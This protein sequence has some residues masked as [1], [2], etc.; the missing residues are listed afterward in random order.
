MHSS[1]EHLK[2]LIGLA[3]ELNVP[4]L[5]IHAFTDGRDTSPTSGAAS[6]AGDRGDLPRAGHRPDR[7]GDRPL[8]RD[9]PRPALGPDRAGRRPALR[10]DRAAP[11]RHRRA[12]GEGRLRARRDRRVHHR[13]DRRGGGA[14]PARRLRPR[15]Q[16]PARPDA[17]DLDEAQ[18]GRRPLHDADPVRRGLDVPGRLPAEAA[19]D[20]DRRGDRG[21]GPRAAPRRRDREVPARDVLLQRRRGGAV[22]GR[23]ARAGAVA[24]RRPDLRLQARDE[25]ARGDRGVPARTGR[26]RTSP[27]RSSTSRTP[28]WS[29]TPG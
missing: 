26:S 23:G 10:G 2:A 8:L 7:V 1:E 24:A 20:H 16:L 3:A 11:R 21:R 25:R 27:S 18:R 9:G 13:D 19:G 29:G 12:G 22:R 4:D 5:V 15:V 17:P 28:T 14:D 6:V